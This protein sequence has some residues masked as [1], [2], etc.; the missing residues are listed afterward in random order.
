MGEYNSA[1]ARANAEFALAGDSPRS[2][3][4]S[5]QLLVRLAHRRGEDPEQWVLD[6]AEG[7]L[8]A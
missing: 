5:A 1:E 8:P 4:L 2:R 3:R 7:R 6:V